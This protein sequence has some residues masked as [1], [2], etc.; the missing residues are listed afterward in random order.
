LFFIG[1][2]QGLALDFSDRA[3][4]GSNPTE[5]SSP[6]VP[7]GKLSYSLS[8]VTPRTDVE[9]DRV[10]DTHESSES[11]LLGKLTRRLF[12]SQSH[13]I[14]R[15]K[16]GKVICTKKLPDVGGSVPPMVGI[17]SW[18]GNQFHVRE[19][20]SGIVFDQNAFTLA[21]LTIPMGTMVIVKNL[22]TRK[23]VRATVNDCGPYT[24]NRIADLSKGLA[25]YLGLFERGTGPVT[26]TIL[27]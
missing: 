27:Q 7:A 11:P 12:E 24:G 16:N 19:T 15:D 5:Y 20:A 9:S 26:V 22:I 13:L 1:S 14:P 17:A 4:S 3:Q 8:T 21:S 10:A 2:T 25:K 18:Y 23:E 6:R